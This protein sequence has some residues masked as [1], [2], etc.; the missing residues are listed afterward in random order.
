MIGVPNVGKRSTEMTRTVLVPLDSSEASEE[1]LPIAREVWKRQ[2]G[3]LKLLSVVEVSTEFDA[4][5]ETAPFSLEDELDR[6]LAERREYLDA[7][8]TSFGGN[9]VTEVR[10]GRPSSEICAAAEEVGEDVVVVMASHGRGGLQQFILGSS[11]LSVV[12]DLHCPV[13]VVH[14]SDSEAEA[15]SSLDSVLL[16]TDGSP[17]SEGIIDEALAILGEP[18][19]KVRL[20][21]VLEHPAWATHSMNAGLVSQY[22]DAS[23]ELSQEH[24]DEITAK[25]RERGYEA[26]AELRSGSAA[27]GILEAAEVHDSDLIAM[28]TH[29]RSGVSRLLLGSVAQRV[30]N[31]TRAPLLLIHPQ[32]S[33][34]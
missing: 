30:L 31:R 23:R 28:A 20:V 7:I 33:E 6:W 5:I 14:M 3:Q 26:A 22:L 27:D 13:I 21:Q 32:S 4:W 9:V 29:G 19:P 10:V 11:A 18:K 24:L 1:A 15:P 16:P 17:F 12:H 2:G 34:S 8:A 25:L